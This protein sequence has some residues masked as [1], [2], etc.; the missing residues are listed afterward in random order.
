MTP[1][2]TRRNRVKQAL[3]TGILHDPMEERLRS[4][5]W[6]RVKTGL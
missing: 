3:Y 2:C 1:P 6:S 5:L 4:R